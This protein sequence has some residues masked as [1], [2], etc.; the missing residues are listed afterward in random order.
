MNSECCDADLTLDF[1]P[2]LFWVS[3]VLDVKQCIVDPRKRLSCIFIMAA[4][5][6]NHMPE[7]ERRDGVILWNA[8]EVI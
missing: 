8:L 3:R 5:S 2:G 6:K 7:T 4:G 1:L